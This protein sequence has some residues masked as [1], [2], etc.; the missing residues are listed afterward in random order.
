M[1]TY[2][3]TGNITKPK[4][5]A[6]SRASGSAYWVFKYFVFLCVVGGF[7]FFAYQ[8]NESLSSKLAYINE[9]QTL[10]D[11]K[12]A[13]FENEILKNEEFMLNNEQAKNKLVELEKDIDSIKYFVVVN[14]KDVDMKLSKM[15]SRTIRM[16]NELTSL[17][18]LIRNFG[19]NSTPYL[20]LNSPQTEKRYDRLTHQESNTDT[21]SRFNPSTKMNIRYSR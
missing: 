21:D 17:D 18:N 5:P 6:K 3:Y 8:F 2:N 4:K 12:I 11:K 13:R 14:N 7:I 9:Q 19:I 1:T 16:D 10:L 20:S 15:E